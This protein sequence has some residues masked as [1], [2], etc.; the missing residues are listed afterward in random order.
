[1]QAIKPVVTHAAL[2]SMKMARASFATAAAAARRRLVVSL[3]RYRSSPQQRP[4][5]Q[6]SSSLAF[7]ILFDRFGWLMCASALAV[8]E[9]SIAGFSRTKP[10]AFALND[11]QYC[12]YT[13]TLYWCIVITRATLFRYRL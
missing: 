3:L 11:W 5:C 8:L 13:A 7:T 12:K 2:P 9:R 10:I 4:H 1:M 6:M